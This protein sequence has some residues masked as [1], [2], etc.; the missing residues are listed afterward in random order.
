[1]KNKT[2]SIL[3]PIL[4]HG[5][6]YSLTGFRDYIKN[7]PLQNDIEEWEKDIYSFI[8]D[9]LNIE[10][11]TFQVQTSGSTGKPKEIILQRQDMINSALMTGEFFHLKQKNTALLSLPAKYIA[12]KMM[13]VRALVLGLDLFITKPSIDII[14]S[15]KRSFDFSAFIPLQ[16]Q[17]AID[18]QMKNHINQL[19]IMII[20]GASLSN[21]YI[22]KLDDYQPKIYASYGM[23]ET[24]THIALQRL[25]GDE[26]IDYFNC[27][28]DIM[29][30]QDA[31]DCL[32]INNRKNCQSWQTNDFVKLLSPTQFK[33]L[34]RTDDIIN[35]GGLKINPLEIEIEIQHLID[36]D[37]II[38]FVHDQQMG[39]RLVLLIEGQKDVQYSEILLN[40]IKQ[41]LPSNKT[42]KDVYYI[43][44]LLRTEN[45]KLDRKGNNSYLMALVLDE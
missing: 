12:G 7:K 20:G 39:Q 6:Q 43:S 14:S 23:T 21:K 30:E 9:W 5:K 28:P 16:L 35:S 27:L 41:I 17:Y 8:E 45:G 15:I 22:N 25:N 40:K 10:K 26:K 36:V 44:Q 31:R 13:I 1:M 38:G 2:D 29:V 3:E 4:W 42:P 18:H 24:I 37:F 32:I 11:E 19:G 33:I 34:G